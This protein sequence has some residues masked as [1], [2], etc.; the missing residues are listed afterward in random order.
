MGTLLA[1]LDVHSVYRL[2]LVHPD[3]HPLLGFQWQGVQYVDSMLPIGLRSAPKIFT[4]VADALEWV[5]RQRGVPEIDHYLD[6]FITLGPHATADCQKNLDIII[7]TCTDLGIP[8]EL[9]S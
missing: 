8:L 6:D 4:A 2:I 3:D 9:R 1:K 5:A 7:Q